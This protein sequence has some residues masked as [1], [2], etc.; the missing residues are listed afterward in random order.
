MLQKTTF[1]K[2]ITKEEV[3]S[4]V[5]ILSGLGS[6][7]AQRHAEEGENLPRSVRNMMEHFETLKIDLTITI[8][9]KQVQ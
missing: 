6:K 5:R 8:D 3:D 1:F 4:R 7:E 2:Q 9:S